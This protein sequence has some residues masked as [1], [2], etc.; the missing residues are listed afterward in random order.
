MLCS[1][2]S[3]IPM[4]KGYWYRVTRLTQIDAELFGLPLDFRAHLVRRAGDGG[5][6]G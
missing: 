5:A 6:V 1:A 2:S 4:T 3:S